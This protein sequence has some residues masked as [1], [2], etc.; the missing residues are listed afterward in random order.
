MHIARRERRRALVLKVRE[1]PTTRAIRQAR[2]QACSNVVD[3]P[4]GLRRQAQ[5]VQRTAQAGVLART[6]STFFECSQRDA[7]LPSPPLAPVLAVDRVHTWQVEA[8]LHL[9]WP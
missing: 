9:P 2:S 1:V 4:G 7:L 3:A 5:R 8:G 6:S